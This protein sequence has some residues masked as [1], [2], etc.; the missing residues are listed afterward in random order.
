MRAGRSR[1]GAYTPCRLGS[2]KS[3]YTPNGAGDAANPS[4]RHRGGGEIDYAA[5]YTDAKLIAITG[6][7]GKT[8]TTLLTYHILKEAGLRVG[9]GGNVGQ[10]LHGR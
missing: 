3:G 5:R 9:L 2:E 10:S 1:H 8:T 7:N 4:C 6:T